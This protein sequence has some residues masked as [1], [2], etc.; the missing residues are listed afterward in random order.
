MA[1]ADEFSDHFAR[2]GSSAVERSREYLKGLVAARK[3]NMERM[4][5]AVPGA[6]E[7]RLQ[8]FLTNI[9]W[10]HKAVIRQVALGVDAAIGDKA[11]AGLLL[12][13]T[14]YP[15]KGTHSVGVS[16]Q[17]CGTLGKVENCQVAVFAVLSQGQHAAPVDV[18]L[19]LP[20]TWTGSPVRCER[21]G[22]PAEDQMQRTKLDLALEMVRDARRNGLRYA[23]VGAD[24]FYGKNP[25]FLRSLEADGETFVMDVN[26]N[27]M[28][29]LD[30]PKP[31]ASGRRTTGSAK[32]RS[33][34]KAIRVDRWATLQH[35]K[36]W[37][38]I[39]ARDGTKGPIVVDVLHRTVWVWDK[40]ESRAHSWRLIVRREVDSPEKIKYSLSNAG[41]DVSMKELTYRQAQRYW[42]ERSFQDGKTEVGMADYQVRGWRPWHHHASLVMMA[43]LFLLRERMKHA[44]SHPLLSCADVTAL[45]RELVGEPRTLKDLLTQMDKRHRKRKAAI[46]S[47]TKR[48]GPPRHTTS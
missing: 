42:V 32:Y 10:D 2:F 19:A 17:W 15:K 31:K 12:D 21:A 28:V 22:V 29:Y 43:M 25:A 48:R 7:Q 11:R 8:H 33:L 24:A 40:Q 23:W 9:D 1:F 16:R 39:E 27:Q 44:T 26:K 30:D 5:E 35:R 38:R 14:A 36:A 18:R 4:E 37:H 45:L 34:E 6:D 3:K 41:P 47:A 13:E 20:R 46:N